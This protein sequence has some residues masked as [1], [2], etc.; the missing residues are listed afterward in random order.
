MSSVFPLN[1]IMAITLYGSFLDVIFD[2][3][4]KKNFVQ[5]RWKHILCFCTIKYPNRATIFHHNN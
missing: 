3:S 2:A 1:A 5:K 4:K